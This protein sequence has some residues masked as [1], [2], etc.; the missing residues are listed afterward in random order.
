MI[1]WDLRGTQYISSPFLDLSPTVQSSTHCNKHLP[2]VLYGGFL[3]PYLFTAILR[4]NRAHLTF[5][6]L[7]IAPM[8]SVHTLS[9]RIANF[10]RIA[11]QPTTLA[12]TNK[13]SIDSILYEPCLALSPT[14]D[15]EVGS[16]SNSIF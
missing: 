13:P 10:L 2:R 3:P 1:M 9:A 7:V 12:L 15:N 8:D 16:S 4:C 5:L 14:L 11:S 6:S